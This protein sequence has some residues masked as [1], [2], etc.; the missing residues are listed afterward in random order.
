[1]TIVTSDDNRFHKWGKAM[2]PLVIAISVTFLDQLTKYLV[3][4]HLDLYEKIV[5]IPG[6]FDFRY[7]QNTGAAWGMFSGMQHWL[8]LLSVVVLAAMVI[9]RKSFFRDCWLDQL[10]F[11]L[12]IGGIVGNFIDRVRLAYVVDFLDF[13]FKGRHFPA[14]NIADSAICVGVAL[15][16]FS[17][18]M[19][20]RTMRQ[21]AARE[22]E[23]DNVRS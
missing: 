20:A 16:L 1:M 3:L 23:P 8:A 21:Q 14:F 2:L 6:F 15:L 17:Q 13:H 9:W 7:I 10:A 5:I 12:L 18:H 11:G 4:G 22:E 19:L